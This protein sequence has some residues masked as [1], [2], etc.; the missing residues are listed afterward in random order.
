[1]N[2]YNPILSIFFL[3]FGGLKKN[4]FSFEKFIVKRF[5]AK[6][7]KE[8]EMSRKSVNKTIKKGTNSSH[9]LLT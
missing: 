7:T 1:M 9:I 2:K 4:D 5:P 3:F 8:K 6:T